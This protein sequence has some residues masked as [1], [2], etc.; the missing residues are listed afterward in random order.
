MGVESYLGVPLFDSAGDK[1]GVLVLMDTKPMKSDTLARDVLPDWGR[2][3]A[4][5]CVHWPPTVPGV[6]Y[7]GGRL[8]VCLIMGFFSPDV[9]PDLRLVPIFSILSGVVGVFFKKGLQLCG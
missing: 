5:H 6:K 9:L 7:R 3:F 2:F 4:M 8:R 1:I